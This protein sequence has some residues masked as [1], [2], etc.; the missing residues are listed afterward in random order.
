MQTI[1][2]VGVQNTISKTICMELEDAAI[3]NF[4]GQ[5]LSEQSRGTAGRAVITA[6]VASFAFPGRSDCWIAPPDL[7]DEQLHALHEFQAA[8]LVTELRS[9]CFQLSEAGFRCLQRSRQT[10]KYNHFFKVREDVAVEDLTHWELLTRL[11]RL[12]W[13]FNRFPGMKRVE[14]IALKDDS[15]VVSKAY[16]NTKLELC[17]GYLVVLSKTKELGAIGVKSILHHQLVSYYT[18]MLT[19]LDPHKSLASLGDQHFSNMDMLHH[20]YLET[21]QLAIEDVTGTD[22]EEYMPHEEGAPDEWLALEDEIP[23][24]PL[25]EPVADPFPE[26]A[27]PR[28]ADPLPELADPLPR[29]VHHHAAAAAAQALPSVFENEC[30]GAFT[31]RV[32]V[33]L[34]DSGSVEHKLICRCPVPSRC[35]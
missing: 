21:E 33:T 27:D 20:N 6:L 19:M 2:A 23:G 13:S 34:E 18:N 25:P 29:P 35:Q 22:D 16:W 3:Y 5:P 15:A 10:C 14:P 1:L 30:F 12:G 26:P 11:K 17:H 7:N 24:G 8:G 4:S 9:G 31:L 28:P 32:Q